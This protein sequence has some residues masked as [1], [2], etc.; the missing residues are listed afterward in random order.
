M[1]LPLNETRAL[2]AAAVVAVRATT[3]RDV[4]RELFETVPPARDTTVRDDTGRD[5]LLPIVARFADAGAT[6][7]RDDT[8]RDDTARDEFVVVRAV[9]VP[10]D[11][12]VARDVA[13]RADPAAR[14]DAAP[15]P[16]VVVGAIGS[17]NTARI[18]IKVEH[19]KNAPASKKTVPIA[20]L[21]KTPKL[22][23]FI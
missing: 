7:T 19:T 17:A 5:E 10:R 20:F 13:P 6:G 14:G 12:A 1:A 4:V 3:L 16:G 15:A 8:A 9:L 21:Y 18:D 23:F 2:F 22:R 11:V